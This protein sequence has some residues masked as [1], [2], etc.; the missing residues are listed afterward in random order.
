MKKFL[1]EI[2]LKAWIPNFP[3]GTNLCGMVEVDAMDEY[4]A[5]AQF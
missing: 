1:V 4:Y 3:D 2:T 5:R